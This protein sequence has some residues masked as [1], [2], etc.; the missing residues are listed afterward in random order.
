M[1]PTTRAVI[2]MLVVALGAT[3]AATQDRRPESVPVPP[4]STSL[5]AWPGVS[6]LPPRP[7]LPDVLAAEDGQRVTT[8]VQWNRRREEMKRVL[9]AYAVGLMPPSPNNVSAHELKS[10][11]VRDGDVDYRLVHLAFGPDHRL[12][13]DVAVFTP[14]GRRGSVPMIIFPSFDRTPGAAALPTMPRPPEQGRGGDAL[15]VPLGDQTARVAA[16][17]AASPGGPRAP[18]PDASPDEAARTYANVF[19]RGY[20]LATYHYQDAGE[21]TIGREA[22]GSW[23][24]RRTLFFP[25]YPG[26]DWG[27]LGA[28][29]WGISRVVDYLETQ[30][31]ADGQRMI[32]TGHSR[33]G[34]AVLVAGAFDQRIA[35]T[36]PAGS[37]AGGTGAYRFN[38]AA[39]GGRE[40]LADMMRKYP[41]W[42]APRLHEFRASPERLP[43][44]QHWLIALVAPRAF[45]SLEGTDDQNCEVDA[46]RQAFAGAAPAFGLANAA[47]RLG[48][49]YASHRHAFAPDD[50]AALLDFADQQLRGLAVAR[51]FDS[52]PA[53]QPPRE[54]SGASVSSTSRRASR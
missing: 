44:D 13:F 19:D 51:R 20:G 37:G 40:G 7:D 1:S 31:F 34:K 18:I 38:G 24:F 3:V 25:A 39:H 35:L 52:F 27:L 48:V 6:D 17:A 46:V 30:S 8:P 4:I 41:N 28:W 54:S 50:W 16:A 14:A 43:F 11:K 42:F 26:Y 45:I 15:T 29:A 21:D 53:A 9:S 22:D 10:L 33:L 23:S 49:N 2:G 47:G 32:A 12:G 5:G 36:A